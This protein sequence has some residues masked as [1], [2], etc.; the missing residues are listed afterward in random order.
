MLLTAYLMTFAALRR[1]E[2]RGVHFRSDFPERN[3]AEWAHH[4]TLSREDIAVP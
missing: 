3:D 2:S 4:Q 1:K